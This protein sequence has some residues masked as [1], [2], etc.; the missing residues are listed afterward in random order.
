MLVFGIAYSRIAVTAADEIRK[1]LAQY[2]R[3]WTDRNADL[4]KQLWNMND[5]QATYM[6]L[7]STQ[8]I[9]GS[10][11]IAEYYAQQVNSTAIVAIHLGRPQI[12]IVGYEADVIC[13]A[14]FMVQ[15][16]DS[17]QIVLHSRLRFTME[18]QSNQWFIVHCAE[19]V[20][21]SA[22]INSA[23]QYNLAFA[24]AVATF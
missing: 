17:S 1:M 3:G 10:N 4:L 11:K 13:T 15:N 19:S 12:N 6:P 2:V 24:S 23:T 8:I 14:E 20:T 5:E 16:W 21:E 18:R 22:A 9:Q 7:G